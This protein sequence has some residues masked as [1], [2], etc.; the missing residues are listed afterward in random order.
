M[1]GNKYAAASAASLPAP[2]SQLFEKD[3][4][5]GKGSAFPENNP[6]G[7]AAVP[8]FLGQNKSQAGSAA[9]G[10]STISLLD[11][12]F[13]W[14]ELFSEI[15]QRSE[16]PALLVYKTMARDP[17]LEAQLEHFLETY[18]RNRLSPARQRELEEKIRKKID[19]MDA[20]SIELLQDL[21]KM[22]PKNISDE[23]CQ[24]FWASSH[25]RQPIVRA[26]AERYKVDQDQNEEWI[27]VAIIRA[28]HAEHQDT[29]HSH[30]G[31]I[32][33]LAMNGPTGPTGPV[34]VRAIVGYG[35]GAS[36]D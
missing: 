8:D 7:H 16:T 4:S 9:M 10:A 34:G 17:L 33:P 26:V 27:R 12:E 24:V 6:L 22:M 35:P 1:L 21:V 20:A 18:I 14:K 32:A 25:F 23:Q 3:G 36:L 19:E 2:A 29:N 30:T 11:E 5:N 13:R 31:F 28:I 15:Q